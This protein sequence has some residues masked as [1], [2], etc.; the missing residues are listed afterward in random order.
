MKASLRPNSSTRWPPNP[1]TAGGF[2]PQIDCISEITINPVRP[3][4]DG[5]EARMAEEGVGEADGVHRLVPVDPG[6][7]RIAA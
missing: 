7:R 3:P 4:L 6:S 2:S 1:L 5:A